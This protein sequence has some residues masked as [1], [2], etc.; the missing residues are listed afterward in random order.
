MVDTLAEV[1]TLDVDV[2]EVVLPARARSTS[3]S[4]RCGRR[5]RGRWSALKACRANSRRL[6]LIENGDE[7]HAADALEVLDQ[8]AH[9][10][11]AIEPRAAE[12]FERE[13]LWL[14][15]HQCRDKGSKWLRLRRSTDAA[16]LALRRVVE[17]RDRLLAGDPAHRPLRCAGELPANRLRENRCYYAGISVD[18]RV[19]RRRA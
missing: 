15:G 3:S 16:T 13:Q 4:R 8:R 2:T 12:D 18:T 10:S 11:V 7:R 19:G 9:D 17:G 14:F 6:G 1:V 5:R